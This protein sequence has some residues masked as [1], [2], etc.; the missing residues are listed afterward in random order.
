MS[1]LRN[2][3]FAALLLLTG[4]CHEPRQEL[5]QA[6]GWGAPIAVNDRIAW[7]GTGNSQVAWLDAGATTPT[8]TVFREAIAGNALSWQVRAGSSDLLVL[9]EG[10]EEADSTFLSV[11]TRGK[12]RV[13][14]ALGAAY[15]VIHQSED[16]RFLVLSSDP[17]RP[18]NLVSNANDI[19]IIDL[20]AKPSDSNPSQR[21]LR[22]S[23][24]T[25]SQILFSPPMQVGDNSK[26]LAL[27][28]YT[29]SVSLV[30]LEHLDRPEYT[31]E[32]TS[33]ASLELKGASFNAEAGRIYLYSA[34]SQDVY[35]L[36]LTPSD[37]TRTN[38]YLPTLN[39]L[40][41]GA[42]VAA[43]A[44]YSQ[45]DNQYVI[46]S[47]YGN[48]AVVVDTQSG[49]TV[50]VPLSS[51]PDQIK[52]FD[53]E[54]DSDGGLVALLMGTGTGVYFVDLDT[55]L[56][57]PENSLET[58]TLAD[59]PSAIVPA[60]E[61]RFIL[62][63][64]QSGL[65]VLDEQERTLRPLNTGVT[66]TEAPV[67]DDKSQRAWLRLQ[68]QA[69]VAYFDLEGLQPRLL[70]LDDSVQSLLRV[71]GNH[72]R[73]VAVHSGGSGYVTLIDAKTPT[74]PSSQSLRGFL[75]ADLLEE[76]K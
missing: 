66:L 60:G 23:G 29:S 43:L 16:G 47:S 25:P 49:E 51:A 72:P 68:E 63:H 10:Q 33:T 7:V 76:G 41:M 27:V 19:S 28:F 8:A 1:K 54:P 15:G 12:A 30:D 37:G 70:Q 18:T 45:G 35:E 11:L 36:Q 31:V 74:Q 38:D 42:S 73:L 4:A 5:E 26:R 3:A 75:M 13:D 64:A 34:Q 52:I 55:V 40:G 57:R 48:A 9:C 14:Y 17:A 53:R 22:S 24:D 58:L 59:A 50:T 44:N 61:G 39:Q 56:Q 69:Q 62:V 67:Y 46:A 20:A 32:L 65:S 71:N 6:P 21:T 2:K